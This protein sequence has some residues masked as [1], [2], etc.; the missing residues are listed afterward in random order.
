VAAH[1]PERVILRGRRLGAIKARVLGSTSQRLLH[2][3]HRPVLVLRA[4]R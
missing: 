2:R 3:T 1:H 4:P